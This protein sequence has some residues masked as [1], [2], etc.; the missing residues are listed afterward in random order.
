M[1]CLTSRVANNHAT[2]DGYTR[3]AGWVCECTDLA[4]LHFA[5]KL[6]LVYLV[7]AWLQHA[8]NVWGRHSVRT[9]FTRSGLHQR[10]GTSGTRPGITETVP[11]LNG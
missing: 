5:A 11:N 6:L 2:K 9:S 3:A 8:E 4:L 7:L 10:Q 1:K